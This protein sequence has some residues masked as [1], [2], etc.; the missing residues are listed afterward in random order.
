MPACEEQGFSGVTSEHFAS[1]AA[2]AESLGMPGLGGQQ[3][4]GQATESG[5]T[6][7][8][9]FNQKAGT[10]KVQC[11]ETPMLLPCGLINAKIKEAVTSVLQKTDTGGAAPL[12]A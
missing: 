11:T 9:E 4:S 7:R 10:L 5:V 1:F 3:H 2:K 6:I 12:Q 8:W